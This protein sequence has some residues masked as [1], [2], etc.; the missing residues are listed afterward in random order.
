MKH[1]IERVWEH[2]INNPYG[3]TLNIETFRPIKFGICV[4]YI[5]T[6]NCFGKHG[7]ENVINH[8]SEHDKIVGGWLNDDNGFYYFDSVKVFKNS[9]LKKAI[10]FAKENQ[11]LA[12]FDLT[13]LKEIK[14]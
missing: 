4:A 8:A 13:N 2:S 12:I 9:E 14:I 7:L 10:E 11:Q 5:D 3:F 6:Q 1:L